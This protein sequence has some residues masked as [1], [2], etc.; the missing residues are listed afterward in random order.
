MIII[1]IKNIIDIVENR[2][3]LMLMSKA[4]LIPLSPELDAR[5]AA[6]PLRATGGKGKSPWVKG[7]ILAELDRLDGYGDKLIKERKK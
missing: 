3:I 4:I 7:L 1:K 5:I 2:S 6:G